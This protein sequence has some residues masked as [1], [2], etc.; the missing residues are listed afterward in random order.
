MLLQKNY[1]YPQGIVR[2]QQK[3]HRRKNNNKHKNLT[4]F[5]TSCLRPQNRHNYFPIIKMITRL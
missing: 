3:L 4:W 2:T 5:D 1:S